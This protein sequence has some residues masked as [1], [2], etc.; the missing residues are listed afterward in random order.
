MQAQGYGRDWEEMGSFR[1][2]RLPQRGSTIVSGGGVRVSHRAGARWGWIEVVGPVTPLSLP[3]GLSPPNRRGPRQLPWATP[4]AWENLRG[5]VSLGDEAVCPGIDAHTQ[6]VEV[7]SWHSSM[8]CALRDSKGVTV[9]RP[10]GL[11]CQLHLEQARVSG[12]W[13][14]KEP[15]G[16]TFPKTWG[17]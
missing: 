10:P 15:E 14:S 9:S 7:C 17:C 8:P 6:E 2:V 12:I 16:P 11:V 3:W 1:W 13:A 4:P 5:S